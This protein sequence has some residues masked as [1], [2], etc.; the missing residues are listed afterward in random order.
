MFMK[1][2]ITP[3]QRIKTK[4]KSIIIFGFPLS[5]V[6]R[7]LFLVALMVGFIIAIGVV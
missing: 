1:D 6:L 7:K 3:E 4:G 2:H 5:L